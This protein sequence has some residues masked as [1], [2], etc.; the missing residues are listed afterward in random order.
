MSTSFINSK[1]FDSKV[2]TAA[3]NSEAIEIND[4]KGFSA[5]ANITEDTELTGASIKWQWSNDKVS[6][7]DVTDSSQNITDTGLKS[8]N[9][10]QH[11]GRYVRCVIA[12]SSGQMTITLVFHSKL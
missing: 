2:V 8:W 5:I 9:V 1:V 4:E 11:Y 6:W 3:T 10:S 12:V 7:V